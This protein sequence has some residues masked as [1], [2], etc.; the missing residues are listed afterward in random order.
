MV[1]EV[2]LLP[3]PAHSKSE[4]PGVQ[5]ADALSGRPPESKF[6]GVQMADTLGAL[7]GASFQVVRWP[8]S[9]RPSDR[10]SATLEMEA[11]GR[12]KSRLRS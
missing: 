9:G 1:R 11:Q 7:L 12:R 10:R 5:M 3:K 4:F 6:P 8:L 2:R